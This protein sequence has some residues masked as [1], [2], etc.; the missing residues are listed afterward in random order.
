M[1]KFILFIFGLS[2]LSLA[3]LETAMVGGPVQMG[4]ST[5]PSVATFTLTPALALKGE[6]E[7]PVV[8]ICAQVIAI[9]ALNLRFGA[10]DQDIV[11]TW[12]R[13]GEVVQV[14]DQSDRD[15]WKIERN[16][17]IGFARSI[18]LRESEC[19]K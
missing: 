4:T 10:S 7:T 9:E 5:A 13:S 8:Q 11:L 16:G 17:E 12:L 1:K 15:W 6:G 18:Y 19:E 3:C 14:V 2:L